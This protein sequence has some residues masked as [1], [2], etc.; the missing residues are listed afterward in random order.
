MRNPTEFQHSPLPVVH[1]GW[2]QLSRSLPYQTQTDPLNAP[3]SNFVLV[4]ASGKPNLAVVHLHHSV[5]VK[6][7]PNARQSCWT[8]DSLIQFKAADFI[9]S[10]IQLFKQPVQWRRR[11]RH[12]GT[13]GLYWKKTDSTSTDESL[14]PSPNLFRF[15]NLYSSFCWNLSAK[16]V[17]HFCLHHR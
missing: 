10:K 9:M 6:S 14:K 7:V 17:I 12:R 4:C 1:V 11:R 2:A 5:S 15:S 8:N 13:Q 16:T 3:E